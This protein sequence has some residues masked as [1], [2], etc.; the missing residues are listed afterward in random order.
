MAEMLSMVEE[1]PEITEE[2]LPNESDAMVLRED[3]AIDSEITREELLANA[4]EVKNGC[5]A[6]PKTVG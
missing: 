6:F 1:L 5:L 2:L 4:H 3:I